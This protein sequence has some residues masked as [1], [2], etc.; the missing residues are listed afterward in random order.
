MG[1][2]MASVPECPLSLEPPCSHA[3]HKWFSWGVMF[4]LQSSLQKKMDHGQAAT[5]MQSGVWFIWFLPDT[6][7]LR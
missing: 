2:L 1:L 3:K 5:G 6:A 4:R 7:W